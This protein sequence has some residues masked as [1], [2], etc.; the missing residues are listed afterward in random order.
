MA[1]HGLGP[2]CTFMGADDVFGGIWTA[3]AGAAVMG[4]PLVGVMA[5]FP[6]MVRRRW[7]RSAGSAQVL[8]GLVMQWRQMAWSPAV[9][10]SDRSVLLSIA[11]SC[12]RS[13]D[14]LR[15][16][17]VRC[18]WGSSILVMGW[19]RGSWWGRSCAVGGGGAWGISSCGC[20]G[21]FASCSSV[22]MAAKMSWKVGEAGGCAAG[23]LR[24]G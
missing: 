7:W 1:C 20:C 17:M 23:S 22:L 4:S 6:W 3:R 14:L 18:S 13:P 9:I 11:H 8:V 2:G 21:A 19:V 10:S 5:E 15:S 16:G 12:G 24:V